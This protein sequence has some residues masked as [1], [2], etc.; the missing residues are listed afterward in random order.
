MHKKKIA[1]CFIAMGSNMGDRFKHIQT[2]LGMIKSDPECHVIRK[3]TDYR[4][5][6]MYNIELDYFYNSV[7]CIETSYSPLNLLSTLKKIEVKLG[8]KISEKR[9]SA[10]P[11]DLDILTYGKHVIESEELTIPHPYIKERKFVLKPWS[12]IASDYMLPNTDM[13]ITELLHN[14]PDTS[15]LRLENK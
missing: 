13:N 6:P 10:R 7:A 1:M 12:D 2:A 15:E 8:R 3:T 4:S 11:I 5:M 9:Y 14:T